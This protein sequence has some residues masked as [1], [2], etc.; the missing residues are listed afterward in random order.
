MAKLDRRERERGATTWIVEHARP[1]DRYRRVL[2]SRARVGG[3]GH[4]LADLVLVRVLVAGQ[5]RMCE[6]VNNAQGR[7][8]STRRRVNRASAATATETVGVNRKTQRFILCAGTL[9]VTGVE[10]ALLLPC[11]V[12]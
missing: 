10:S 9:V 6:C 4:N 11:A 1:D 12:R 3:G 7:Q 2:V 5:R 8:R